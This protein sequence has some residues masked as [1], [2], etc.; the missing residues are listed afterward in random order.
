MKSWNDTTQSKDMI[1]R[2][3]TKPFLTSVYG[4]DGSLFCFLEAV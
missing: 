1:E 4:N 3:F 2:N